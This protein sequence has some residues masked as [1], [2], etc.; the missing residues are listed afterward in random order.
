[1]SDGRE[2]P[3]DEPE[4]ALEEQH[5]VGPHV[6]EITGD[7]RLIRVN[8]PLTEAHLRTFFA[9]GHAQLQ[10]HGYYISI[11]DTTLGTSMTPEARR[12]NADWFSKN[13]EMLGANIIFGA[14]LATRV[15]ITLITRATA[16]LSR[17][18]L[19][20]E[21]VADEKAAFA[22]ADAERPRLQAQVQDRRRREKQPESGGT[23]STGD[24]R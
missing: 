20:I 8:G 17:K 24:P 15:I 23:G 4:P 22:R 16:L 14:G 3:P 12:A 7:V 2:A 19:N 10:R 1:M 6:I 13:P 5:H 18:P 21:F 9:L 11:C